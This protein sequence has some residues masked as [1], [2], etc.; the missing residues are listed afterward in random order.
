MSTCV[1]ACVVVC[2]HD[3]AAMVAKCGQAGGNGPRVRDEGC[4]RGVGR[5]CYAWVQQRQRVRTDVL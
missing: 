4:V 5:V 1:G 2:R 3:P